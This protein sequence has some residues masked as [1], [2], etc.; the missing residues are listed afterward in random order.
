MV[1]SCVIAHTE[2]IPL[3][4]PDKVGILERKVIKFLKKMYKRDDFYPDRNSLVEYMVTEAGL[5]KSNVRRALDS[6]LK[7]DMVRELEG[8]ITD[9]QPHEVAEEE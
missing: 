2:E 3:Q 9:V 1:E 5:K 4:M 8:L 7:K 6:A